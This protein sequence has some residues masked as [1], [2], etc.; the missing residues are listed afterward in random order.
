MNRLLEA[1]KKPETTRSTLEGK[2]KSGDITIFR[3]E[4]TTDPTLRPFPLR[5]DLPLESDKIVLS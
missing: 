5:V 1:G 4:S 3:L 2:I